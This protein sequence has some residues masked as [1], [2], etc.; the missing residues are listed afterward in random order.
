MENRKSACIVRAYATG[1]AAMTNV[2]DIAARSE[3]MRRIADLCG[4][5]AG[6]T[7][8]VARPR[9]LFVP[10]DTM[11]VEAAAAMGIFD[12][13]QL[14]GG[15]VP[16]RFVATKVITH[17]L[18]F[19][20]AQA[21]PEWSH[22]LGGKLGD[23]VLR[24]FSVFSRAD[25][26]AAGRLLLDHGP[27]RLKDVEATSGMGQTVVRDAD[28]LDVEIDAM[29]AAVL[30]QTGLVIEENLTDVTTYSVGI[31]TLF[32]MSIAY[33]GTQSLTLNN[34]EEE[35]YGGSHLRCV[36]GGWLQL[37]RLELGPELAEVIDRAQ[38]YDRAVSVAYPSMFAS[39][40]NYDVVS[41]LD[42]RGNKQIG[43]LEQSWRVGGASGAEIAAFEVF[44]A[45]PACTSVE[46]S[47]VEIYG[48]AEQAPPGA[49]IYFSGIDPVLGPLIKYAMTR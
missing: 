20:G 44:A 9:E 42:G 10:D 26:S 11:L 31:A 23:A 45:Y 19:Q 39:R 16:A 46:A 38:H 27:V 28:D 6:E 12:A 24:G 36:R 7:A 30:A 2:H 3:L 21:P 47:T 34:F 41:G 8:E 29:D 40:R 5:T 49:A 25:A 18:P 43:V 15:A 4:G 1:G 33:W 22:A 48:G 35:V 37:R 32:G 13:S 14:Y 17:G